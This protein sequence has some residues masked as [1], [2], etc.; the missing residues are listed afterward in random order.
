[1]SKELVSQDLSGSPWLTLAHS[2]S[3][4]LTLA[5]TDSLWLYLWLTLSLSLWLTLLTL[6]LSQALIGSQG[7]CS[8]LGLQ[9]QCWVAPV[10]PA[11]L[12]SFI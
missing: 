4:M 11:L 9:R 5:L 2:G 8:M 3:L 10:Y 12:Q 7:P 6:A 1:M